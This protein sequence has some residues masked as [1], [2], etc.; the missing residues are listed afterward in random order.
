MKVKAA[1][2]FN[3]LQTIMDLS[4]KPMPVKLSAKLLRLADDLTKENSMIEKQRRL[5]IEKYGDKDENGELII[6]N[7]NVTFNK[8]DNGVKAQQ[9]LDEL[10]NLEI[11]LTD[12]NITEDELINTNIQLSMSQLAT[13]RDFFHKEENIE[14]IE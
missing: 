4:E 7:G 12:R 6:E 2:I 3:G 8:D 10:A 14:V 9:E 11:D 13:L 1:F 5:I